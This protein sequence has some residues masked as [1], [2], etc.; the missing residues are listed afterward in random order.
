MAKNVFVDQDECI[1]CESC[2]EICLGVFRMDEAEGKAEVYNPEG[3]PE[4]LI[5]EAVDN[6]PVE[7]IHW[8]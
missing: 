2:I 4:D 5:Q 6:C 8:G 7:C 3:A 1:A